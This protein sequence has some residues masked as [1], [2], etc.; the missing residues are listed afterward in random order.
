[1]TLANRKRGATELLRKSAGKKEKKSD[2]AENPARGSSV[3][4]GM[5]SSQPQITGARRM[6]V[7]S[8]LVAGALALLAGCAGPDSH[9]VSAPPPST[10][11]VVVQQPTP[12]VV[13]GTATQSGAG[14][15]IVTQAPPVT[16]QEVVTARPSSSHVWVPGYW[17]WTN[18]RYEWMAGHWEVPPRTNAVWV[19]PRW[20]RLSDG[21]YRFYEG[22][23]E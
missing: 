22:Y 15:V 18:N 13:A 20:E 4:R 8:S 21:S 16:Q 19:A 17:T 23:W 6:V 9:V 3:Q 2:D 11:P 1:M 7:A 12:V 10:A 14:T 5:N